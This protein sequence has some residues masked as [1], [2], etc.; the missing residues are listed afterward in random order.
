ML[1]LCQS[2]LC[3]LKQCVGG[4][5][6]A[7]SLGACG[8]L[9]KDGER[10]VSTAMTDNGRTALATAVRPR[11]VAHLGQSGLHPLADGREALAARL[12][13]ADAAQRSLDVQYFIWNKDV[14]GKVLLEHLFHAADRG[15]RVRLLLDDLGTAPSDA[16][17]LAIDSHPNIEVRMFNPVVLRSPRLLGMIADLGRINRRMHNKSFTADGQVAIVGGR[18][19]GDEYFGAHEAMNYA[20]LDVVVIGPVVKEVSNQFDL[21]WNNQSSIPMAALARQNTTPE[22]FAAKRAALTE[23]HTTAERSAYAGTVRDSEFARHLRSRNVSYFWGRAAIVNDHPDKVATSAA[24]IETHLAPQLRDVV[25]KTKRELFLVSPYFVPGK[26]GVDLLAGV[27]Q[28]GARVVVITNSLASTDGV[29]VHSKYQLYRKTLL[30]AGVELYEIKPTAGALHERR[31][32]SFRGPSGS[33]SAGLHAKTFAFDRRIGFIGSYNLD[34]RSSKLNTEMGV[35]F[36]C[37]ALAKRLPETTERD[38]DRNAYHVELDRNRLTWVT[39]E[40]DKHVRYNSEPEA[41]LWNRIKAQVLSWLP[42]EGLL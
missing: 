19:I 6:I 9:P 13:L 22:Q 8:G 30:E 1:S 34:P 26:Q 32:G 38:L 18:N 42:I 40:G 31:A 36:N 28:R 23:Y 20:D 24:K 41:S 15:V 2:I 4:L 29:L 3:R 7:L 33:G 11:V 14:T 27:R 35:L 16:V 21:Y 10:T 39:R 12:A 17:L 5:L 25:G 37:P